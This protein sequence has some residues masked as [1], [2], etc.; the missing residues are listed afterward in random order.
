M[1]KKLTRGLLAL[2]SV[3]AVAWVTP[4]QAATCAPGRDRPAMMKFLGE[5]PAAT[6]FKPVGQPEA[7]DIIVR[8]VEKIGAGPPFPMSEVGSVLGYTFQGARR[9]AFFDHADCLL[10]A[11]TALMSKVVA[12]ALDGVGS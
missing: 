11:T 10:G 9:L 3:L 5:P 4:A 2:A 7:H 12:E 1:V 6:E 8:I